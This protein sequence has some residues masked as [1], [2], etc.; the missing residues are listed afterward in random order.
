MNQDWIATVPVGSSGAV[1]PSLTS[2][3]NAAGQRLIACRSLRKGDLKVLFEKG[4]HPFQLLCVRTRVRDRWRLIRNHHLQGKSQRLGKLAS[5]QVKPMPVQ[6][7]KNVEI[8]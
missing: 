6:P 4:V 3:S 5:C 7:Q 2:C 8:I 1:K